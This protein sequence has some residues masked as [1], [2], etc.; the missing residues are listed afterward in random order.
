MWTDNRRLIGA[1]VVSGLLNIFLVG[2][3]AGHGFAVHR[4]PPPLLASGPMVPQR[5]VKA[6]PDDQRQIFRAA[7]LARRDEIRAARQSHK[8]LRRK[9]E[10]DIAAQTF[11]RALV[12]ED[13][14]ALHRSNRA[15]DEAVSAALIDALAGLTPQSRAALVTHDAIAPKVTQPTP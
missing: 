5:H 10:A 8:E 9:T 13:F 4:G 2:V 6:L 1:L 15:I 3:L 11:D 12:T 7:M 14:A